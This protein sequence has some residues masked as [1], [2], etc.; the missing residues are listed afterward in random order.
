M[1]LQKYWATLCSRPHQVAPGIDSQ[2]NE[3]KNGEAPKRTAAITEERQRYANYRRQSENHAYVDKNVHDKDAQYAVSINSSKLERL[4]F[5]Q[6]NEAQ[7][8]C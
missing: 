6:D 7:D 1:I 8:E 3:E 2:E 4:P 5:R